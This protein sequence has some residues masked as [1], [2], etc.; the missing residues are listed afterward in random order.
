MQNN[1]IGT[2]NLG[3][4]L[5]MCLRRKKVQEGEQWVNRPFHV[6]QHSGNPTG[7]FNGGWI[8]RVGRPHLSPKMCFCLPSVQQTDSNPS[9]RLLISGPICTSTGAGLNIH[10]LKIGFWGF[11]MK[12]LKDFSSVLNSQVTRKYISMRA[13][14]VM[15]VLVLCRRQNRRTELDIKVGFQIHLKE[16]YICIRHE[17]GTGTQRTA[18]YALEGHLI[19]A[20]PL[21]TGDMKTSPYFAEVRMGAASGVSLRCPVRKAS[22][23]STCEVWVWHDILWS[24]VLSVMWMRSPLRTLWR[25][26]Q[27]QHF[28]PLDHVIFHSVKH[29]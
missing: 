23:I 8:S 29:D 12:K 2:R 17:T 28:S 9:H 22:S 26:S 1:R 7:S 11:K 10:D 18:E 19:Q 21:H 14:E 15:T 5:L 3:E 16:V 25:E 24:V 13:T 6:T 20:S 4:M 27:N